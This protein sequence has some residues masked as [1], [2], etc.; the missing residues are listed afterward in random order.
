MY[1]ICS[2][3]GHREVENFC[4]IKIKL[5]KELERLVCAEG[6][7]VFLFGGFGDF[8]NLCFEVV[9]ELKKKYN[10]ISRIYCLEDERYLQTSKRPKYLND[11]DYD[12]YVYLIP[13]CSHWYK[14][15]Y[16]RNIAMIDKSDKI[17]FYAEK[18][19]N[20][21]AFKALKYAIRSSKNFINLF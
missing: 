7:G 5:L 9:T 17:L 19:E 16:Y 3:F 20:S 11:K 12:E 13:N 10:H 14:R 1:K 2:F 8:D 4:Q 21:G 18:R 15:I 6:Y